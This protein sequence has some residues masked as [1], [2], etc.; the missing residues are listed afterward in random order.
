MRF[1]EDH[2]SRGYSKTNGDLP[3]LMI[4]LF[5]DQVNS[6]RLS[7]NHLAQRA[8][9]RDMPL[10]VSD[11][12]GLQ[13]QVLSGAALSLWA[14]VENITIEDV[15]DALWKHWTLV[16]TWAMRGTLHLLS[17]YSLSTYVAALKTRHDLHGE[18]FSY[19]I[20]PGPE[21]KEYEITRTEQDQITKA[22]DYALDQQTLTREE[23]AREIIKRTKLRPI[24]QSH[25]LSGFGSLLQQAAHQG[26]L[27]FGPSQGA[28]VTFTRPDQWLGRQ[29]QPSSEQ[30]LRTLLRQFYSTYGPATFE[31]FAHWWGVSAR[32][33]KP[34]EQ[35]IAGELEQV[36]FDHQPSKML[37]RDVDQIYSIDEAECIRLVPSWDTYVMFYHPR[38]FFVSQAYRTRIFRQIQGNAPVLL[39]DGIAAGTWEK[40]KKKA[41]IEIMVR[42]FK[43]L[44][45]AQ[46]RTVEEEGGLLREFFGTNVQLSFHT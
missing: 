3:G 1:V 36:E 35:L 5:R 2:L 16:K 15:E 29:N 42:P 31:D 18:K 6:W 46:K 40:T 32:E 45:S 38:E 39:V 25:L 44:S 27:I 20:G 24:L 43:A 8:P 34:L 37:S 41:G 11:A 30:A 17:S 19:R 4:K 21:D 12:C 10:V 13:A 7:K 23:L 14:R 9:K 28:K 33:A 26:S 22:V